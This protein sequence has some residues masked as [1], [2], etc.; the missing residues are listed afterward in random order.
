MN[1]FTTA[2]NSYELMQ[3][4]RQEKTPTN[5][6]NDLSKSKIAYKFGSG[7]IL[8]K[9]ADGIPSIVKS[10]QVDKDSN[11]NLNFHPSVDSWLNSDFN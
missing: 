6:Q 3:N 2:V 1:S 5:Q 8:I 9:K 4:S 11:I 7:S 10:P